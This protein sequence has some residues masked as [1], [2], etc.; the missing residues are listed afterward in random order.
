MQL[1]RVK[2][3]LVIVDDDASI[4]ESLFKVLTEAG[5]SVV[6]ASDGKEAVAL[7]KQSPPDLLLLDLDLPVLTGFDVLELARAQA[8]GMAVVVI[9]GLSGECEPG[10]LFGADALLEKPPDVERL[11]AI[12]QALLAEPEEARLRR[13]CDGP[14]AA[15]CLPSHAPGY[16]APTPLSGRTSNVSILP[17][18][19]HRTT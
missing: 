2:N 6:A 11:L 16:L 19:S 18:S 15:P 17:E 3:H 12:I 1:D 7:L 13:L 14:A 8:P 9:T 10:A 5:Y 4:R